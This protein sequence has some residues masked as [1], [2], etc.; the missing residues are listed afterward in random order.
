MEYADLLG[1]GIK[2]WRSDWRRIERGL[3]QHPGHARFLAVVGSH[4]HDKQLHEQE[5]RILEMLDTALSEPATAASVA[6]AH[7]ATWEAHRNEVRRQL[8][9]SSLPGLQDERLDRLARLTY[10]HAALAKDIRVLPFDREEVGLR[11]GASLM[12]LGRE[13]E[14]RAR[15][16]ALAPEDSLRLAAWIRLARTWAQVGST[17]EVERMHGR[18][19]EAREV[20]IR[21]ERFADYQG[22]EKSLSNFWPEMGHHLEAA[23]RLVEAYD[24]L[25][26]VG[27]YEPAM[28][29]LFRRDLVEALIE[30]YGSE[31]RA[32]TEALP[33]APAAGD[34]LV[35]ERLYELGLKLTEVQLL[36]GHLDGAVDT[37]SALLE[38]L[39]ADQ[40]FLELALR[41][42]GMAE[43]EEET[44]LFLRRKV[45]LPRESGVPPPVGWDPS[46]LLEPMPMRGQLSVRNR[47]FIMW[48]PNSG[49]ITL[50]N[51]RAQGNPGFPLGTQAQRRILRGGSGLGQNVID[52]LQI[53]TLEL[54]LERLQEAQVSLAELRSLAAG[55]PS[56]QLQELGS[57]V[58]SD[59]TLGSCLAL[60]E[61]LCASDPTSIPLLGQHTRLLIG[62]GRFDEAEAEL[63][64]FPEFDR[65]RATIARRRKQI[66]AQRR[67]RAAV[68]QLES[69]G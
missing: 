26:E 30:R 66:E 55:L 64:G 62:L 25:R 38:R 40:Q 12:A 63:V 24:L 69:D 44:L 32:A 27:S 20:L 67:W 43:R 31:L 53:L 28:S 21:D 56:A 59:E 9:T 68:D 65:A 42:A 33:P 23:G 60:L 48:A 19:M 35:L 61:I 7:R 13:E 22:W 14:G 10:R 52:R 58:L 16:A 39:P 3:V 1:L 8:P 46:R 37:F 5:V 54:K 18:I 49:T 50:S 4:A 57:R 51:L 29:L 41:A 11:L 36:G 47:R 45:R 6:E 17:Q 34:I 2:I 15:L